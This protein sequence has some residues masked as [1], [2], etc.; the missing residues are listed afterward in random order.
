MSRSA[1]TWNGP[2]ER[3]RDAFRMTKPKADGVL[4][5]VCEVWSHQFGFELRLMIDGHGL[6]LSSVVRP[7]EML[8]QV[9]KYRAAMLE[10]G[11]S[12]D[13]SRA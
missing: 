4:S 11:W 9:E 1:C 12:V 8:D 10:K 3:F 6:Q 13:E 2:P 5:A 7:S